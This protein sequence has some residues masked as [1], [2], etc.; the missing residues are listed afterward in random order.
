MNLKKAWKHSKLRFYI[1][2]AKWN[3]RFWLHCKKVYEDLV[4]EE[5]IDDFQVGPD[6]KIKQSKKIHRRKRFK[7]YYY[8]GDIYLDNPGIQG[9]DEETMKAWMRK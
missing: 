2:N 6:M 3:F 5:P 7:G 1:V 8:N 9:E 4:Y